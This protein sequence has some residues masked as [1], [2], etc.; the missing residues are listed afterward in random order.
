[1]NDTDPPQLT[2][3]GALRTLAGAGAALEVASLPIPALPAP[4]ERAV[5]GRRG[6]PAH[7][8][9]IRPAQPFTAPVWA[10]LQ[11]WADRAMRE[12][13]PAQLGYGIASRAGS[14]FVWVPGDGAFHF[15]DAIVIGVAWIVHEFSGRWPFDYT[16]H[17][18]GR[19]IPRSFGRGEG[20]LPDD[21]EQAG[22][23]VPS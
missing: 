14:V 5:P 13:T 2:R 15:A 22:Q 11:G 16:L 10:E 17:G 18:A 19:S 8:V 6:I 3:R 23:P 20:G 9:E 4:A 7:A 1:M 12:W 21:V